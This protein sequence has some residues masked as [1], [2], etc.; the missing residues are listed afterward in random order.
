[1]TT[2]VTIDRARKK[3][4]REAANNGGTWCGVRLDDGSIVVRCA[5]KAAAMCRKHPTYSIVCTVPE[6]V[7]S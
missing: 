4:E 6:E 2:F 1:M 7:A 3:A 5:D